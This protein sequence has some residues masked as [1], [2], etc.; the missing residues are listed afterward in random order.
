MFKCEICGKEFETILGF[1][2]HIGKIHKNEMTREEY[3]LK[4]IGEKG[5]CV[6]C[7]KDTTFTG[8]RD[9]YHKFCSYKCSANSIEV[10]NKKKETYMKKTGYSHQS[11]NPEVR[12]R[13]KETYM[14]KTGYNHP[15]QNPEVKNKKNET[16]MKKT[17]YVNPSQNPE[18]RERSK[19]TYFEKTGYVNPS[20]NPETKEKSKQTNFE[21]TGYDYPMQ[22]PET[23]EKSKQTRLEKTGYENPMQDPKIKESMIRNNGGSHPNKLTYKKCKKRYPDLVK[24]EGLKEGPNGEILAHCKNTNCKN[25]EKNGG[26]FEVEVNQIY[27]RQRGINSSDTAHFY[28]CEECKHTC[29]LYGKSAAVLH[30]R[31]NENKEILYTQEEYNT[32]HEEVLYRQRIENNTETNF[33]EYCHATE[34]LHVHH[35][36]PQKIVPGY[37]L[38]PDNGIIFCEKCHYEKGHATGTE[39]STGNLANKICK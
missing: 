1:A 21:K 24:I 20:Q 37:A 31:M 14:K 5:K 30:N 27:E 34:N 39:C 4:F 25:S 9:G 16:Y 26:Y 13:T 8:L 12:E 15:L 11:Q 29:P 35:E 32:W 36:V 18:V 33:C 23:R 28:C 19:Q 6:N 3:Y 22:N 7:G 17:G 10:K 2:T 38:D